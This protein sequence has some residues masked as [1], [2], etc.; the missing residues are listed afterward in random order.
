MFGRMRLAFYDKR[1]MDLLRREGTVLSDE[2]AFL[3]AKF[4]KIALK[5]E[6]I[7]NAII[8]HG[9]K[10]REMFHLYSGMIEGLMPNP[11]IRAG[12]NMLVATL[13]F[14]EPQRLQGMLSQLANIIPY[15]TSS[16]ER[17]ET[18]L[19]Y[20][21]MSAEAIWEKHTQATGEADFRLS[22]KAMQVIQQRMRPQDNDASKGPEAGEPLNVGVP[23]SEG[24]IVG[25]VSFG[26]DGKASFHGG[27]DSDFSTPVMAM[28]VFSLKNWG[29]QK[30]ID[31]VSEWLGAPKS[32]W[33]EEHYQ[34]FAIGLLHWLT[35]SHAAGESLPE[36]FEMAAE[37][38]KEEGLPP[39][40]RKVTR[41][42]T[43]VYRALYGLEEGV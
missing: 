34:E 1:I 22:P 15:N 35:E 26:A 25:G 20:A 43:S 10:L 12:G 17:T 21:A 27:D 41:R 39:L 5:N 13:P 23:N 33:T 36:V 24:R 7:R 6:T 3:V 42:L 31:I 30:E 9:F 2:G 37:Y 18:I 14:L 29:K 16:A 32:D 38:M 8:S 19:S 11:C 4:L 28:A 40:K